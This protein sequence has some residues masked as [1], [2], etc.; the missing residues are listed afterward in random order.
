MAGP[1][2]P[3]HTAAMRLNAWLMPCLLAAAL[4]AAGNPAPADAVTRLPGL[5]AF[6]DFVRRE[7]DGTAAVSRA[8]ARRRGEP[9]PARCR[10]LRARL[11]GRGARGDLRRFPVAR[12][13]TVRA[14]PSASSKRRTPPSA[15]FLFVPRARLHDTPLD[16]KARGSRSRWSCGPSAR[17]AI[18]RWP[19]IWHEGTDLKQETTEH[20]EG[21][22]RAAAVRALRRPEQAGQRLRPCVGE[23]R[24]LLPEQVRAAQVQLGRCFARG[25]RRFAGRGARRAWQCFA[26][27][28]DPE[29]DEL[30]GW[31]NGARRPLAG[32]SKERQT[33]LLRLQRLHAGHYAKLPGKQDRRGPPSPKDQYYNPPEASR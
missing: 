31:L 26:M 13:R 29:N 30:T 15:R 2:R 24:E 33:H 4:P 3:M 6:W 32:Q 28:F 14:M 7:P 20:R 5:V 8:R 18:T 25:A 9:L 16:I 21:G 11:L 22:A 23:R 1:G 19:G 10:E 27:T 17:A 12:P